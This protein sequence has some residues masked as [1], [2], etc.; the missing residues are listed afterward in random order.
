MTPKSLVFSLIWSDTA[1]SLLDLA[2]GFAV[3][4][5][6]CSG[7]QLLTMQPASFR[8]LHE[9]ERNLRACRGAVPHVR[10]ALSHRP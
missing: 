1:G 5:M 6:L 3:A 7:Y 8:L 10:R 4:G 9:A 2:I